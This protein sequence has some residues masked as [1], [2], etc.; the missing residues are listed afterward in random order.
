M[1]LQV[2]DSLVEAVNANLDKKHRYMALRKRL[3]GLDEL[4]MYDIYT[5]MVA[6][7]DAEIPYAQAQRTVLDALAV[8][9][10][11]YVS[12]VER[13]FAE[14]W[15]DVYENR[16]KRSGAY[17]SGLSKPHP[18]ILLNHKNTLDSQFTLA[19]ELGHTM[20]SYLSARNQPPV[21]ADYVIFVAE[22]A[23]TVNE[24]LLMRYLLGKT[25][26]KRQRAYLINYFLE[27]FRTTVYRQT[28]FAEFE[29]RCGEMCARGDALTAEALSGLYYD[30]NRRYYGPD[31][32]VDGRIAIEWARIPH[33]YYDYYV[34][35]Y[36]TGF[37]AAIAISRRILSG[38]RGAVEDYLRFL[39]SGCSKTPIELLKIAGV[40][41]TTPE[42]VEAG[43]RL[44]GALIDELDG[45]MKG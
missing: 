45:L 15:I 42:P 16:G 12:V 14:R 31:T 30:L 19:H 41:M 8:L 6:D 34:F 11:D 17:S 3:M 25:G 4:H 39:S 37:S 9:G 27:Q 22:V 38:D 5:P 1:P 40:D 20:H 7:A 18:Y 44:F 35:Q 28:M 23:S 29:Q 10:Q 21:Y 13:A 26:D 43:L 2:Y 32:T 24:A 33:F 36:A